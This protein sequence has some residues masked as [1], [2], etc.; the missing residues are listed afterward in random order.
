MGNEEHKTSY[1]EWRQRWKDWSIHCADD[2]YNQFAFMDMSFVSL[3]VRAD[4]EAKW[5]E[6]IRVLYE[7]YLVPTEPLLSLWCGSNNLSD[8]SLA[9]NYEYWANDID[10][11]V[12]LCRQAGHNRKFLSNCTL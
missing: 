9:S 8:D 4:Y 12:F 7:E 5:S 11:E 10:F 2:G 1:D 6:L 3:L